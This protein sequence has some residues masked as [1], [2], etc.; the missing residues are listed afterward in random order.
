MPAKYVNSFSPFSGAVSGTKYV[1]AWSNNPAEDAN[2]LTYLDVT[3][4]YGA[5]FEVRNESVDRSGAAPL[6]T[7][8]HWRISTNT[9]YQSGSLTLSTGSAVYRGWNG[10][11]TLFDTTGH[12][13]SDQYGRPFDL[14]DLLA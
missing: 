7:W 14:N 8:Q 6:A 2:F 1:F 3:L 11:L 4:D 9:L 12:W 13:D 10:T 5:D